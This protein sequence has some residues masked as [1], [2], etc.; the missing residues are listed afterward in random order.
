MQTRKD[1]VIGA[2]MD[3]KGVLSSLTGDELM[4]LFG[5]VGYDANS[6]PFIYAEE[7]PDLATFM[8][9]PKAGEEDPVAWQP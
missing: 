9:D 1:K 2:A 5:E 8:P 4:R 7:Y 3:E 6:Q